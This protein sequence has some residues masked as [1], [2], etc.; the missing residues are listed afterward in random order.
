MN[1]CKHPIS[2]SEELTDKLQANSMRGSDNKP[3]GHIN[4]IMKSVFFSFSDPMAVWNLACDRREGARNDCIC[5]D[6]FR[7]D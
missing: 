2:S 7:N 6:Y 5:I 1:G 4:V 3:S